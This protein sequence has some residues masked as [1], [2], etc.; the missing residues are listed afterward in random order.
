MS[1]DGST[2]GAGDSGRTG[3]TLRRRLSHPPIRY[4]SLTRSL[5]M[6]L[7]TRSLALSFSIPLVFSHA[8]SPSRTL[9]RSFLV[10]LSLVRGRWSPPL[11]ER[12][13]TPRAP[14]APYDGDVTVTPHRRD[15]SFEIS[16]HTHG[17]ARAHTQH[18]HTR[19]H[20]HA[21]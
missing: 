16:P 15:R 21:A 20:T 17:R 12:T 3:P 7:P 1:S 18:T 13:Q 2:G 9:A 10:T 14:S 11:F 19:T 6:P 4:T 8:R 5:P